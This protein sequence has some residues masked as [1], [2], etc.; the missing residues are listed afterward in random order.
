MAE[1]GT[2]QVIEAAQWPRDRQ[3][4]L[5]FMDVYRTKCIVPRPSFR[6]RLEQVARLGLAA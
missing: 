1:S 2:L 5:P 4:W 3:I 6:L